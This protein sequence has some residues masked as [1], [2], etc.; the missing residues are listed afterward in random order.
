[1][2]GLGASTNND[3]KPNSVI[4]Y[5]C[6]SIILLWTMPKRLNII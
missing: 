5:I 1:M 6:P 2:T 3:G 4:L